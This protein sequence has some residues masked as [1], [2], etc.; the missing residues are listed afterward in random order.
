MKLLDF[1]LDAANH[2]YGYLFIFNSVFG[3]RY[4]GSNMY[5]FMGNI[6]EINISSRTIWNDMKK[7]SIHNIHDNS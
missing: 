5:T 3:R 1:D 4:Y 6:A 2:W 7:K